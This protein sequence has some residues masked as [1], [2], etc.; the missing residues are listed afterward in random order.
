MMRQLMNPASYAVISGYALK[1]SHA[2]G[3]KQLVRRAMVAAN[4]R[5]IDA[6]ARSLP[7]ELQFLARA[8]QET[9]T[10]QAT[11][12]EWRWLARIEQLRHHMMQ[13]Y[14]RVQV[15]DFGEGAWLLS[16]NSR[17]GRSYRDVEKFVNLMCWFSAKPPIWCFFLMKLLRHFK[18]RRGLELGTNLGFSTQYLAAAM[19]LNGYGKITT[20]EGSPAIAALATKQ[21]E[22]ANLNNI[23]VCVGSFQQT[24]PAILARPE[25]IDFAFIDGHHDGQATLRYFH[26]IKTRLHSPAILVFDDINWSCSMRKAWQKISRDAAV[27]LALDLFILGVCVLNTRMAQ[28][29]TVSL[30]LI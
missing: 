13:C 27:S 26:Q 15:R 30:P 6:L 29:R 14:D 23:E 12:Q 21:I 17:S 3:W 25:N 7:Q 9:F 1:L 10:N 16:R 19:Q 4:A 28:K 5:R 20:I 24:L 18:P 8:L 11:E 22:A 2:L